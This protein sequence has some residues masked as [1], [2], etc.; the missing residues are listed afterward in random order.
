MF[1]YLAGLYSKKC[2]GTA[3]Y[4]Y[5]IDKLRED[6]CDYERKF[7]PITLSRREDPNEYEKASNNADNLSYFN[8]KSAKFCPQSY[9][10]ALFKKG[11]FI[12]IMLQKK[13]GEEEFLKALKFFIFF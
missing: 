5:Q 4:I 6:I 12:L 11:H 2:F 10:S 1:S 3:E 8:K 13:C 9:T 7:G